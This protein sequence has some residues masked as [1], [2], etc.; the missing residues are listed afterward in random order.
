MSIQ[1]PQLP[2]STSRPRTVTQGELEAGAVLKLGGDQNTHTLS[3][4]E[5]RL[6]IHKV[7]ANKR[8]DGREYEESENLRKTLNY[9]DTFARFQNEE[10]IKAV[11]RLLSSHTEL[12]MFERSQLGSLCCDNSE[13][14]KSLIPS[15]QN[16]ISDEALQELLDELTKLRNFAQ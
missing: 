5:A 16:K 3:N 11:E 4:S 12:E 8:R 2:P 14:A 1:P 7:L 13:E 10:N 9:L 15:L 6:V